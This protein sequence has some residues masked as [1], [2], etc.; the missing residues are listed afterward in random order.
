MVGFGRHGPDQLVQ[1]VVGGSQ[2]GAVG[3]GSDA[4]DEAFE[5]GVEQL[6]IAQRRGDL[7]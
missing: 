1:I 3:V 7:V 5:A 2:D 4:E 6:Q